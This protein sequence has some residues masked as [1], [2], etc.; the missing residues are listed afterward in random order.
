[1]FYHLKIF[2]RKLQ[3]NMFSQSRRDEMWLNGVIFRPYGTEWGSR[4]SL[5]TNI[6][7]RWDNSRIRKDSIICC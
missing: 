5:F 6:M 1:M 4:D 2:L 7:S 3:R